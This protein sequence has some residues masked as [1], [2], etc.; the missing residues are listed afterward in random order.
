MSRIHINLYGILLAWVY[1]RYGVLDVEVVGSG[2][3]GRGVR[4]G[5]GCVT[6]GCNLA[7]AGGTAGRLHA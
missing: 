7:G 4:A 6:R 1:G 2:K 3:G 5:H